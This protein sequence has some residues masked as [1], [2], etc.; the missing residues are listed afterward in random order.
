MKI[1][2]IIICISYPKLNQ[3][4]CENEILGAYNHVSVVFVG[5]MKSAMD[6]K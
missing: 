4:R 2:K 1:A 6:E 3:F 5:L